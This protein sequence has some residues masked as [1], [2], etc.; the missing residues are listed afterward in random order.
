MTRRTLWLTRWEWGCCGGPLATGQQATLSVWPVDDGQRTWLIDEIGADLA[1][2]ID[3]VER[4]HEEE[5]APER[6]T[7]TLSRLS[8]VSVLSRLIHSERPPLPLGALPA[9]RRLVGPP[10]SGEY[11]GVPHSPFVTHHETV[12]GPP[13]VQ[14][15]PRIP[16][17]RG[18]DRADAR[19][20]SRARSA[21][22]A[23]AHA[24]ADA[25][26]EAHAARGTVPP[27]G[28]VEPRLVGYLVE[29]DV[30]EV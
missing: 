20:A 21:A 2:R 1:A 13:V 12:P 29:L 23:A 11:I 6:L 3:G 18:A 17:G 10:G 16:P 8:T 5:P 14:E 15:T 9:A 22:R 26:A 27:P 7:G 28:E 30:D 19:S 4:H 24:A 25:E